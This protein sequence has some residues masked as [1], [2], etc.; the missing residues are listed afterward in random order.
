MQGATKPSA[1]FFEIAVYGLTYKKTT[2]SVPEG[3][4]GVQQLELSL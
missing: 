1:T 3:G 2:L 4:R